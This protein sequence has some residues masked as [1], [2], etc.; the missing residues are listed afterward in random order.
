[1]QW[2]LVAVPSQDLVEDS[3]SDIPPRFTVPLA[4]R[5][6]EPI[7][8]AFDHS[9]SS[10]LDHIRLP[11]M[12]G[13]AAIA[14]LLCRFHGSLRNAPPLPL[15]TPSRLEHSGMLE[16]TLAKLPICILEANPVSRL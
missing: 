14:K 15:H 6:V 3:D 5:F 8:F 7:L 2:L 12:D 1:M 16:E 4:L 13:S 11:K 10:R 9:S